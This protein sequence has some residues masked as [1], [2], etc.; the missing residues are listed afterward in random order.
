MPLLQM[1]KIHLAII[2][3]RAAPGLGGQS[4]IPSFAPVLATKAYSPVDDTT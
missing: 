1:Q 3:T 2:A 4:L